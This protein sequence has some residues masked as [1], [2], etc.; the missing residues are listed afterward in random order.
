MSPIT[1]QT[2]FLEY[3]LVEGQIRCLKRRIQG[4]NQLIKIVNSQP[5]GEGHRPDSPVRVKGLE[6]ET[7][8]VRGSTAV[9]IARRWIQ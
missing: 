2:G 9:S 5:F 8:N 3:Y 7:K 4:E 1:W 6:K